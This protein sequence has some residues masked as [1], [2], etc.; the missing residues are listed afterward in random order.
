V[1][2]VLYEGGTSTWK[3]NELVNSIHWKTCSIAKVR[4]NGHTGTLIESKRRQPHP[5][6]EGRLLRKGGRKS[7]LENKTIPTMSQTEGKVI[8][9]DLITGGKK[10]SRMIRGNRTPREKAS[11]AETQGN[12]TAFTKGGEK[13]RLL[14]EEKKGF[15]FITAERLRKKRGDGKN[16][17]LQGEGR[18]SSLQRGQW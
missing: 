12:M 18:G 15:F 6:Q 17:P 16:V 2:A 5:L 1:G 11:E 14:P 8:K 9:K 3:G 10:P 13:K 7:R 4:R